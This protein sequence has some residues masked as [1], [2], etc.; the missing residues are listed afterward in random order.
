MAESVERPKGPTVWCSSTDVGS[1]HENTIF[2]LTPRYKVVGAICS[3]KNPSHAICG[4][5]QK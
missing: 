2:L 5:T 4:R 3:R 1:K